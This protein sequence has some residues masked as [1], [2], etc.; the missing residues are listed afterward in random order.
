MPDSTHQIPQSPLITMSLQRLPSALAETIG[1][2]RQELEALLQQFNEDNRQ[3]LKI[4][5]PAG[6]QQG[7]GSSGG[8]SGARRSEIRT[9]CSPVFGDSEAVLVITKRWTPDDMM[10][11]GEFEAA[12]TSFGQTI[13]MCKSPGL[14]SS[15]LACVHV[16]LI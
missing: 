14:V 3:L 9:T 7:S 1:E 10:S 2:K 5:F 13:S 11:V 12:K 15:F 6:S 4:A 8:S 16:G